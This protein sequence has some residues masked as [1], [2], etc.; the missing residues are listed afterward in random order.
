MQLKADSRTRFR[1][2]DTYSRHEETELSELAAEP[3][4]FVMLLSHLTFPK[5]A[6]KQN[7]ADF[8]KLINHARKEARIRGTVKNTRVVKRTQ[9][10]SK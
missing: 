4:V 3:D 10:I 1:Y 9:P 5:P 7:F 8:Y 2:V 6:P